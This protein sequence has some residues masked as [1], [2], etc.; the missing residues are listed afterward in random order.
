M[1]KNIFLSVFWLLEKWTIPNFTRHPFE[2]K[3]SNSEAETFSSI[4]S[5]RHIPMLEFGMIKTK[6]TNLSTKQ[7]ES[8]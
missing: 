6:V 4:K 3:N 2:D 8:I 7:F 5:V 1:V